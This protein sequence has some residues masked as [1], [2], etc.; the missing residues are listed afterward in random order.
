MSADPLEDLLVELCQG[1][2]AAAEHV[3]IA[4]EPYLRKVVRRQL[5]DHLR[6]K[7]DSIDIVQSTWADLLEGFRDAGWRFPNV[8]HLRA[9]LIRVT[10]NRFIDRLRQHQTVANHEQTLSDND[11][12]TLPAEHA[13]P[14]SEKA[15][16]DELWQR[17]LELCPPEHHELLRLRRDGFR[18]KEIAERTGLHE[19]SV[20]RIL[21]TL[22]CQLAFKGGIPPLAADDNPQPEQG[23]CES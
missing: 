7:F 13:S 22:A 16:A 5:P 10:R 18:L 6:S 15:Q 14:P 11:L 23:L 17:M 2:V 20:R 21:R 1:D 9:F 8:D 3:F 19:G 4:Y 12:A